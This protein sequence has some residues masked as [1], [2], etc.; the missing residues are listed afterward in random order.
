MPEMSKVNARNFLR[1]VLIML[2][3]NNDDDKLSF[4]YSTLH[5]KY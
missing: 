1:R 5:I 2:L 4:F 3:L